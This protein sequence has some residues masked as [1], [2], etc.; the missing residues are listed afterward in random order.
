MTIKT[1][2][3]LLDTLGRVHKD[4]QSDE[5]LI[6]LLMDMIIT[7]Y[8]EDKAKIADTVLMCTLVALVTGRVVHDDDWNE[9]YKMAGR[10]IATGG[11]SVEEIMAIVTQ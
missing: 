6:T 5:Q 1:K 11:D 2:Q 3:L 7:Y 8:D 4:V 10:I 9:A